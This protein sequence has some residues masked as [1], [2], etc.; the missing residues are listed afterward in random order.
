MLR[1]EINRMP[2]NSALHGHGHPAPHLMAVV[3]GELTQLA[4]GES[5]D[6]LPG[7]C[8]LSPAGAQHLLHFGSNG[9][10][11]LVIEAH[12]PFWQRIFN[13]AQAASDKQA[14]GTTPHSRL[15]AATCSAD[16]LAAS[17]NVIIGLGRTLA[18]AAGA[19][20]GEA[21]T[22]LHEAVSMIELNQSKALAQVASALHRDR[23]HFTRA[24]GAWLSFRPSEYRALRRGA[25]AL[26]LI[27]S[28]DASLVD[29]A[30]AS[31]YAHQSHM[32]RSFNALFGRPPSHWR[33]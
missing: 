25:N 17:P 9:A 23:V 24:F 30:Y 7:S 4:A 1:F 13:R 18:D 10:D 19:V 26:A 20:R 33:G 31:G 29:I 6:L 8:R 2:A 27:G 22:W 28:S 11:C 3:E 16:Q 21:P 32:T 14:F 5:H 15:L 12:G